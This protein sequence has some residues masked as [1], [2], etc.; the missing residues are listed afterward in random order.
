VTINFLTIISV[1]NISNAILTHHRRINVK[2]MY[3]F[4]RLL[5]TENN[6]MKVLVDDTWNI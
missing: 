3:M 1:Y 4:Y 5:R 6:I 2:I